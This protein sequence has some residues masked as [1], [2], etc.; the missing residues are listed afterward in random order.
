MERTFIAI[1]PDAVQ[2]GLIGPIIQRFETKGFKLVGL[3]LMQVPRS[4]AERHYE[5]HSAK[6][7]FGGLVD[8]LCSAPIVAMVWEGNNVIETSR[9]MMGATNPAQSQPGTIR[10]DY[11]VDI[12]RNVIHGS[13]SPENAEREIAL[14]F[15][16]EE[17]C[18]GWQR[19]AEGWFYEHPE[20]QPQACGV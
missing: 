6:P 18:C 4:L 1:K 20:T 15:S 17:L 12:G 14:F 19:C 13:D 3:K 11:A 7:F 2:R 8:F 9:L 5:A 16:K 10:G